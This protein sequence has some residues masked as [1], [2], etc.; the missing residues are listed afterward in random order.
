MIDENKEMK[1]DR[2]LVVHKPDD[3]SYSENDYDD[4]MS[5]THFDDV[6]EETVTLERHRFRKEKKSHKGVWFLLVLIA[7][8]ISVVCGLFYSGKLTFKDETTTAPKPERTY[9]TEQENEF[10]GIITV[11]GTYLFFEGTEVDGLRGLENEVKYLKEGTK[12]II[13][14]EENTDNDFLNYEV[15][16]MLSSYGIDYDIKR[17]VSSGLQSKYETTSSTEA[18]KAKTT[19]KTTAVSTSKK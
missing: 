6:E 5:A 13:Q 18:T 17:I 14:V 12:F 3:A 2:P 10:E 11:K 9:T 15:L 1:L 4:G 16:T 7:I 19:V 8:G